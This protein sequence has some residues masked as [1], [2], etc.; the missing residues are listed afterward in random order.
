MWY[1]Y[2][3]P[4]MGDYG[5][6]KEENLFFLNSRMLLERV[7]FIITDDEYYEYKW[8]NYL[9]PHSKIGDEGRDSCLGDESQPGE[10]FGLCHTRFV[11]GIGQA[12]P[13]PHS[14]WSGW[15]GS[16]ISC[17]LPPTP[18][19]FLL[20]SPTLS[21]LHSSSSPSLSELKLKL[22]VRKGMG[23]FPRELDGGWFWVRPGI[24]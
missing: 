23:S 9:S 19:P 17:P 22:D 4:Q 3:C 2:G 20:S 11:M 1:H 24:P 5:L 16:V 7:F 18:S 12:C 6:T 15:Q 14:H 13:G 8:M 21:S 10:S